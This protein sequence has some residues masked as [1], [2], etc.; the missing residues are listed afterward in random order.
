V[1]PKEIVGRN[2]RTQRKKR[3]WTQETLAEHAGMHLNEVG[4][5]ERGVRDM[6]ISTIAKLAVALEVPASKLVKDL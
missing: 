4:R 5:V 3:D 1:E 6:R 2:V